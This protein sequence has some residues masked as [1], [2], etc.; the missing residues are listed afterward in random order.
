[1][2]AFSAYISNETIVIAT[3]TLLTRE[4]TPLQAGNDVTPEHIGFGHKMHFFPNYRCC[5]VSFGYHQTGLHLHRF[6]NNTYGCTD[7]EY[8]INL[9]ERQFFDY[10]PLSQ[11]EII[12]GGTKTSP[13]LIS[14][15]AYSRMRKKMVFYVINITWDGLNVIEKDTP[16][17]AV[18][19]PPIKDKAAES[20][21]AQRADLNLNGVLI[22]L[23]KLQYE[24]SQN[25]VSQSM[26]M[27][28]E[29][30]ITTML[31][32]P[33]FSISVE[34]AHQFENYR[35]ATAGFLRNAFK[36]RV[37]TPLCVV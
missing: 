3:D 34:F 33:A 32:L 9:I 20:A 12:P 4:Y 36:Y 18:S 6:I 23:M 21:V 35:E 30:M 7:I 22:E 28:G 2:S 8:L 16:G 11:Y 31:S 1:M 14:V 26:P 37:N 24:Q 19:I 25:D 10:L 15:F 5:M 29:V 27:G 13:G 17:I